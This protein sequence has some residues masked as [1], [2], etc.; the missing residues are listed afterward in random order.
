MTPK[1]AI[2][3]YATNGIGATPATSILSFFPEGDEPLFGARVVWTPGRG[4]GYRPS[5]LDLGPI[6]P[7]ERA[8]QQDG[9]TLGSADTHEP[10]TVFGAGWYGS[11]ETYGAGAILALEQGAQ[12]E[13]YIEKF[14][15]DGSVPVA[16]V[17]SSSERYQLGAKLR[18]LDQNNGDPFSLSGRILGGREIGTGTPGPGVLFLEAAASMKVTPRVALTVNPKLAAFGNTEVYGLGFGVNF[19]AMPGLQVIGEVTPVE[20]GNGTVWA[21]GLRYSLADSGFSIDANATNAIGRTGLGTVIAQDDTRF[22]LGL[23]KHFNVSGW[24]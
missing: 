15:N 6:D 24:R 7:R 11:G 10:G 5:Y 12:F 9:F 18:F 23:T 21:T 8:L 2:D 14:S 1:V 16:L 19:E 3:L 22:S 17:P 4:T 13:G 20:G